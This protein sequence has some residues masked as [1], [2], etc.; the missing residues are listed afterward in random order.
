MTSERGG[1]DAQLA[2][3]SAAASTALR[4][5]AVLAA[6]EKGLGAIIDSGILWS[7]RKEGYSR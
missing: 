1:S 7:E 3:N 5:T 6:A 4:F 2:S